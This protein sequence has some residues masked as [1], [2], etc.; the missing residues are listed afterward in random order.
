MLLLFDSFFYTINCTFG[1]FITLK[2]AQTEIFPQRNQ[3]QRLPFN[4]SAGVYCVNVTY[5][6]NIHETILSRSRMF[7][8]PSNQL[9]QSESVA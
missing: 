2:R 9:F 7:I 8:R 3:N 4:Q 5:L 6:I 1:R